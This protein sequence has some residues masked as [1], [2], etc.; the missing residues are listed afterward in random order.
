MNTKLFRLFSVGASAAILLV[1]AACSRSDA[2]SST[3]PGAGELPPADDIL[4]TGLQ[5]QIPLA[6]QLTGKS[7]AGYRKGLRLMGQNTIM[8]RGN[9]FGLAWIDDCAYVTTTS[10][11]QL[12]G[13]STD[14]SGLPITNPLNGM[15]VIDASDPTNPTLISILQSPAMLAPHESLQANE[16]RRIIV[17][18]L[19]T[20]DKLDVYDARDCR[21]PVLKST[22]TIPGF[23]GHALCLSDDGMTAYAT[24]A[25]AKSVGDAIIDLSDISNP[26]LMQTFTPSNHDCGLS[27]DGKRLYA[28][29]RSEGLD[30]P[31]GLFVFDVSDFQRRASNPQMKTVGTLLW[32]KSSEGE[33]TASPGASHTARAFKINGRRYVYSN[34]EVVPVV[35]CPWAHGRL[36]DISD[37]TNPV[38]VSDIT[39]EVEKSENCPQTLTDLV[40]YS[41]HYSGVDNPNNATTLFESAYG[42]GLRVWDIRDPKSPKEIAYWH[43]APIANTQLIS[44]GS[45]VGTGNGSLWDVVPNYVRYRPGS[46]Q[47]WIIG[48]SSGFQILQF[49]ESAGPT[50]PRPTGKGG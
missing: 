38:K 3:A 46:G 5:G 23:G 27:Q 42:A 14:S 44:P 19:V 17:G 25:N 16:A 40:G 45:L 31:T 41:S 7:A 21:H 33:F 1:S 39:L 12:E 8:N 47:I 26:K 50:A 20:G 15:A 48:Y 37:E 34:D 11:P 30:G 28:A 36:I 29:H 32:T 43:P 49:T 22:L 10:L 24:S 18:T 2:V 6:D 13:I 35:G 9:N 4:E